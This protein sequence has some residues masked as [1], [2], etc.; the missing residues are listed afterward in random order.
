[1]INAV[2][3]DIPEEFLAGGREVYRGPGHR[4]GTFMQKRGPR[5]RIAEKP[6]ESKV[7][8]SIREAILK[9]GLK[10]GMTISF[11]HPFRDGDFIVNM[12]M[13]EVVH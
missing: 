10:D 12:D 3:R 6:R 2:G 13:K 4:D 11:H 1:M 5:I 8:A 9:C 7:V